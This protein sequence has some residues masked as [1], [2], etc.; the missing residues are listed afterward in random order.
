[1]HT[2]VGVFMILRKFFTKMRNLVT[3]EFRVAQAVDRVK[4]FGKV[5]VFLHKKITAPAAPMSAKTVILDCA[6][7]GSNPG[8]PD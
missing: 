3:H 1:M 8:H 2:P 4:K 6:I 7:R 5:A